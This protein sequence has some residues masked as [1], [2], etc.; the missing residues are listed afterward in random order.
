MGVDYVGLTISGPHLVPLPCFTPAPATAP[1]HPLPP[2]H[3]TG[4]STCGVGW[5]AAA[6]AARL[7]LRSLLPTA[8]PAP[9]YTPHP[10]RDRGSGMSPA[11]TD[12]LRSRVLSAVGLPGRPREAGPL[13]CVIY[14]K[15]YDT[16]TTS[17]LRQ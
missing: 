7:S 2:D 3:R 11:W 15:G 17:Y 4:M 1:T 16:S 14:A 8:P 12:R 6:A 5:Q 10:H 9:T 13:Q